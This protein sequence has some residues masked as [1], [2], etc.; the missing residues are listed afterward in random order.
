MGEALHEGEQHEAATLR[1]ERFQAGS[2]RTG[3]R[4]LRHHGL[5]IVLLARRF[6]GDRGVA[7]LGALLVA[8]DRERTVAQDRVDPCQAGAT[9]GVEAA[10]MPEDQYEGVLHRFLRQGAALQQT[11]RHTEHTRR[12]GLVDAAECSFIAGGAGEQRGFD[13]AGLSRLRSV[14]RHPSPRSPAVLSRVRRAH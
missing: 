4:Q 3:I 13:L 7:R 6:L 8:Q 5:G 1:R 2:Q 11:M 12:L 9:L 10:G 14:S